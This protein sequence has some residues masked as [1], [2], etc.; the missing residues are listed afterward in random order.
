MTPTR[1]NPRKDDIS[2]FTEGDCHVFAAAVHRLT[3]WPIHVFNDEGT[4]YLHAFV[5]APDGKAV[6]IMGVRSME[7][8]LNEWGELE[9][10]HYKWEDLKLEWGANTYGAY[11][12]KRAR[13]MARRL[14]EHHGLL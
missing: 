14:L 7:D 10:L 12:V 9:H 1:W 6:D 5:V 11:S 3:G 13:L 4:P 2:R 8:L